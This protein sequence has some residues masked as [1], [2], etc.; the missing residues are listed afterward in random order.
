MKPRP[1]KQYSL[2]TFECYSKN[3]VAKFQKL[4]LNLGG[5]YEGYL[6]VNSLNIW[7]QPSGSQRYLCVYY[8]FEDIEM[9]IKC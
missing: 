2:R 8:Y 7:N 9:E 4:V 6:T 5:Y 3:D 1:A